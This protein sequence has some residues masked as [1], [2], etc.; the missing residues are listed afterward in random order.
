MSRSKI[1]QC[2]PKSKPYS[3]HSLQHRLLETTRPARNYPSSLRKKNACGLAGMEAWGMAA[4]QALRPT[5]G[6]LTSNPNGTSFQHNAKK[7]SSSYCVDATTAMTPSC[8]QG[9]SKFVVPMH[10][11]TQTEAAEAKSFLC[12]V[13]RGGTVISLLLGGRQVEGVGRAGGGTLELSNF[14]ESSPRMD[15]DFS[16]TISWGTDLL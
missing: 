10:Y 16:E 15:Q 7:L 14:L 11:P 3:N 4:I 6:L 9:S 1:G 8:C 5:Q 13:G 12:L 2:K